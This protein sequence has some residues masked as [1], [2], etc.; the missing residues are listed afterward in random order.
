MGMSMKDLEVTA[1]NGFSCGLR[2][3]DRVMQMPLMQQQCLKLKPFPMWAGGVQ[4]LL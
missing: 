2:A 3:A 1:Q 4:H